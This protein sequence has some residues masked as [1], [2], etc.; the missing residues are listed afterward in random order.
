MAVPAASNLVFEERAPHEKGF[1]AHFDK[2]IRPKLDDME[3]R[4]LEAKRGT[5]R[6]EL[7]RLLVAV[8]VYGGGMLLLH[9]TNMYVE[10]QLYFLVTATLVLWGFWNFNPPGEYA[11]NRR[12][13]LVPL[14]LNLLGKFR[15]SVD[16]EIPETVLSSSKLFGSWSIYQSR[17]LISGTHES[18]A[19]DFAEIKLERMIRKGEGYAPETV[20][21]G[22]CIAVRLPA[23]PAHLTIAVTSAD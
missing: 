2:H 7:R 15:F 19:F 23:P 21:E 17:T 22:I 13:L 18:H 9:L 8:I 5:L 4:R 3:T 12:E 1:A 10:Y 14:I 6:R 11:V 16:D 20:F